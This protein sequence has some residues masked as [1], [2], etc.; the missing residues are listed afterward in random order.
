MEGHIKLPHLIRKHLNVKILCTLSLG[1]S[2][3]MG[4][5]IYLGITSQR[6][7]LRK[8][9]VTHGEELKSLAYAGIRHP[10][11][12]GDSATVERQL[13]DVKTAVNDLDIVICDFDGEIVFATDQKIV[14]ANATEFTRNKDALEALS[15]LLQT[16][17]R[18]YEKSFEEEVNGK[19][20]LVNLY[21]VMNLEECHHCHGSSRKVLGGMIVRQST[22]E[23]YAA[24][25]SLRNRSILIGVIGIGTV[26]AMLYLLLTRLVTGPVIEFSR[27]AKELTA[28]DLTVQLHVKGENEIA[29]LGR[30]I[31]TM[32]GN[33][34]DMLTIVRAV[35]TSVSDVTDSVIAS[36]GQV[37]SGA[38][39]QHNTVENAVGFIKVMDSS[40][41][42]VAR[43]AE[44]LSA[45]AEDTSSAVSQIVAS[46]GEVDNTV[47]AFSESTS[48][49]AS[50]IDEMVASI[51]QIAHSLQ[52]LT[53]SSE[54]TA[55]SLLE[56]SAAV[57][58][59]EQSAI[60]SVGLTERVTVEASDKG[61]TAV[62]SAI[63]GMEDIRQSVGAL[64]EVINR[65]GKRSEEIGGII[66]VID[67]VADQTGLLAL[68][69]AILAAQAGEHGSSF[70]VVA[71]EIKTLAEKTSTSTKEIALLIT[72][73]QSE[74]KSTLEM[75]LKGMQSVEKGI[76]LVGEINGA[77]RSILESSHI[78]AE[79]SAVIQRAASEEVSGIKQITEAI[80]AMSEQLER[81]SAATQDQ[82][83]GSILIT[84]VI[85]KI[86][87][88]SQQVKGAVEEQS[89]G[90][91]QI[92]TS[93]ENVAHQAGQIVNATG[94]QKQQS[95][96]IVQSI[97]SIKNIAAESVSLAHQMNAEV[98]S[99][100][101]EAEALLQELQRFKV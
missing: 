15:G 65:L 7:G 52:L 93:V 94:Q 27:K 79:K 70:A 24:I 56:I 29:S 43:S 69:A 13:L 19:R 33:L 49:A 51:K 37:L 23:T 54:E 26:I 96:E 61:M 85:E 68:N 11:S 63:E 100:K 98:K 47:K 60:E 17:D 45:S 84:K 53:A 32:A 57:R 82:S 31:N 35:T 76:R 95:R 3:I 83:K 2:L 4:V 9:M 38:T 30:S 92:A 62:K 67:D 73:V 6:E 58:E 74:T 36:S 10:M 41:S 44:S 1:V 99:L 18:R 72:S 88:L 55:S 34:K 25:A 46:I 64:S 16:G 91:K 75:A 71:S 39:V 66:T 50:S 77:L 21:G 81:I 8:K 59:V 42:D 40:I 5:V 28:G 90:S 97:D 22:E 87:T 14:K 12:V 89:V 80:R 48:D 101:K 86:K 20:Y 78:S